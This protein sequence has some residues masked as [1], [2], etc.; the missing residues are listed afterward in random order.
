MAAEVLHMLRAVHS[1]RLKKVGVSLL[2]KK[3]GNQ[4]QIVYSTACSKDKIHF[5][6]WSAPT[7]FSVAALVLVITWGPCGFFHS[8]GVGRTGTFIVIDSMIDMMHMEQRVDVFS[9]VSRIREQRCQL[10][11]TDVSVDPVWPAA[12][13]TDSSTRLLCSS[14]GVNKLKKQS[15]IWC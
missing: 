1:L 11:Q 3:E 10:I 9:S 13:R 15:W 12:P 5:L 14:R 6:C 2:I 7:C 8:A 4:M